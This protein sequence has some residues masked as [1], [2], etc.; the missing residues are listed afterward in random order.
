M[1][2]VDLR[3]HHLLDIVRGFAPD[4]DP[5]Y[6]RAPGEN[7]VRTVVR[8]VTEGIDF[9]VRFMIGPDFICAPCSHLQP[10]G[11]CD[12]ILERHDPPEP[13]DDYNDPLDARIFDYLGLEPGV[14]M[15]VR[16]FLEAVN[17]RLPGIEEVCTHPTEEQS[18][19]RDGLI[20]GMVVLGLR[21]E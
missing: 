11:R 8:M 14:E 20:Q 13:I 9:P 19:R 16:E 7:G 12:R 17:A 6:V 21:S 3:P 1:E 18:A 5:D 2:T 15:T 4:T 10:N